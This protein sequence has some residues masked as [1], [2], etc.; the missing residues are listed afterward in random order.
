MNQQT[1]MQQL[2]AALAGLPAAERGEILA[3]YAEYFGDALADG[4]SEEE[5]AA[6]LGDPQRLAR[7][8]QAK[9]KLQAW[10]SRR[11]VGNL[12]GVIGALAGLG[13]LNFVLAI[14]FMIYL[15]FLTIGCVVSGVLLFAGVVL[16]GLWV[17]NSLFDWPVIQPLLHQEQAAAWV[18]R[19]PVGDLPQID[20]RGAKGEQV[21]IHRD[22]QTGTTRIEAS[23]V[24]GSVRLE[25]HVDGT[26]SRLELSDDEG[27]VNLQG[28]DGL[29]DR[30]AV[31]SIGLGLLLAGGIGLTIGWLLVRLT[32]RVL[33]RFGRYQLA[34]LSG[35]RGG[36]GRG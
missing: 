22:P 6:S 20:I 32:W 31:L 1:F 30:G 25:R 27:A 7:E 3:D 5:V 23:G 18:A 8:L 36:P 19:V 12:F 9:A 29:P 34:L 2:E 26:V 33:A 10:E 21:V 14:P 15:W 13:V 24:D 28:F 17:S 4:R 11:S 35:E 16:T